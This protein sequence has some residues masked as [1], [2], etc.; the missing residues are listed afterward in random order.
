MGAGWWNDNNRV[1]HIR[2]ASQHTTQLGRL[3]TPASIQDLD[4][5]KSDVFREYEFITGPI[6]AKDSIIERKVKHIESKELRYMK[7]YK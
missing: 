6:D 4:D 5:V 7:I 2:N 3:E 1:H